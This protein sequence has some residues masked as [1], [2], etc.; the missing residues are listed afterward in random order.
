MTLKMHTVIALE[1]LYCYS[2]LHI[3]LHGPGMQKTHWHSCTTML[4]TCIVFE[5]H[6]NNLKCTTDFELENQ[7][8]YIVKYWAWL[9]NMI[10][11]VFIIH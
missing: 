8:I 3:V 6:I 4:Y 10:W 11:P 7:Y 9:V 2:F 5:N 1:C